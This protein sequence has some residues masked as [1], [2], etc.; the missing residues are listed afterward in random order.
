[1]AHLSA[2]FK[3]L[4]GMTPSAFKGMGRGRTALDEVE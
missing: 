4:T 2:Q 1:V 3:K